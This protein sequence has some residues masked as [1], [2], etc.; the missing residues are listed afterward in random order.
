MSSKLNAKQMAR[1]LGDYGGKRLC[2]ASS[3]SP[4]YP[5]WRSALHGE[6]GEIGTRSDSGTAATE[7]SEETIAFVVE[8]S[9][10]TVTGPELDR[11]WLDNVARFKRPKGYRFGPA[12]K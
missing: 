12:N 4:Y 3:T 9:G 1:T 10:A 2:I 7:W 6:V 11:L 5:G 8:Q